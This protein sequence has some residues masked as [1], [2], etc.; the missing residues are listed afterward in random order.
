MITRIA[1]SDAA[2]RPAEIGQHIGVTPTAIAALCP[3]VEVRALA[4][5]VNHAVDGARA[6]KGPT[7]RGEDLPARGAFARFGFE[8]PRV[9]GIEE[10][11]DETTRHMNERVTVGRTCF[12]HAHGCARIFG[13][14]VREH[15]SRGAAANDDVIKDLTGWFPGHFLT[16]LPIVAGHPKLASIS[17]PRRPA[18][19]APTEGLGGNAWNMS[20]TLR[21]I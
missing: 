13:Q 5:V 1:Q 19:G 2:L 3:A 11:L 16:C 14:A 8:L 20:A 6:A 18:E 21:A 9:V 15:R 10:H 12:Q 7:L 17:N 4:A